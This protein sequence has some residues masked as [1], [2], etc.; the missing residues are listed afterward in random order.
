MGK[1]LGALIGAI[2]G[3]VL[4]GPGN[5][6]AATFDVDSTPDVTHVGGCT[7]APDDCSIR[8]AVTAANASADASNTINVPAGTYPIAAGQLAVLPTTAD[9][10]I[11]AGAGAR[12]TILDAGGA[13][14]VFAVEDGATTIS[15]MTI[16]GGSSTDL[17]AGPGPQ[18]GDGGGIV[19]S[20]S[21]AAATGTPSLTLVDSTVTG[22]TAA[23]QGA[24]VA[25]PSF[26]SSPADDFPVTVEG[27]TISAN[28]LTGGTPPVAAFGAGI[29]T[30]GDLTV[31][32]STITGNTVDS[33]ALVNM[34]GGVGASLDPTN[35]GPTTVSI[36]NTTISGN[37]VTGD[38]TSAGGGLLIGST[39]PTVGLSVTNT[40]IQGNTVNGAEGDC[41]G[42]V[43]PTSAANLTGD[44]SCMFMDAAS[45]QGN[46]QLAALGN[47]GGPTDTMLPAEGSPAI[48]A[49]TGTG[50]P[51]TDQRGVTR[52]QRTACDIGAVEVEPLPPP[53]PPPP[54]APP[55]APSADLAI[56]LTAHP[57]SPHVGD[58][59][60]FTL[61]VTNAGPDA[62][63]DTVL[64]G[65]LPAP[66]SRIVPPDG[67]KVTKFK[68]GPIP[69]RRLSCDLGTLASGATSTRKV[70]VR[71]DDQT[72][73]PRA[74]AQVT[75]SVADPVPA[76]NIIK[77]K[78]DVGE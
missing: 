5:A 68:P 22:N 54:P 3:L 46:P 45:V 23:V 28:H 74:T 33:P 73:M 75:S 21:T 76:N 65:K 62:A 66:A 60:K 14:R 31:T 16:T 72:R 43:A 58:T 29:N 30:F 36:T 48:D 17:L 67:C 47:N 64:T 26:H 19:V 13:S 9:A 40:I 42:V 63:T 18:P 27:S 71:P 56:A 49:G 53:P 34:G 61:S 55:A 51:A 15:G 2:V 25:A 77:L 4:V 6:E 78:V 20:A 44:T 35:A 11:I 70:K 57:A 32:N 39:S 50:C 8:D 24:G 1:R 38:P 52:P 10:T 37:T 69:K 59:V 7:A 41:S 12:D